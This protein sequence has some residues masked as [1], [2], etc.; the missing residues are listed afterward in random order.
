VQV[1]RSN[2]LKKK[3]HFMPAKHTKFEEWIAIQVEADGS[4]NVYDF[5]PDGIAFD[6]IPANVSPASPVLGSLV[7][8]QSLRA[9][10]AC[11]NEGRVA[12]SRPPRWE[13]APR[14]PPES[15]VRLDADPGSVVAWA[16][17]P[18]PVKDERPS[19][20]PRVEE[21]NER[22]AWLEQKLRAAEEELARLRR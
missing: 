22:C 20:D 1:Y 7:A 8:A 3:I 18:R 6:D 4:V 19:E 14:P 13:E 11:L 9:S 16:M 12:P 2:S 5:R 15:K 10:E 21:L 17:E